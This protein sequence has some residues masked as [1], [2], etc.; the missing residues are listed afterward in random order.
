M[1]EPIIHNREKRW[2]MVFDAL[3]RAKKFHSRFRSSCC[4]RIQDR[5]L[6]ACGNL[7]NEE[8]SKRMVEMQINSNRSGYIL[9]AAAAL[10]VLVILPFSGTPMGRLFKTRT[11]V[12]S[13][14]WMY[15]ILALPGV[16]KPT[17]VQAQGNCL[18]PNHDL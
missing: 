18:V 4:F 14:A 11:L 15:E 10:T 7:P 5:G 16:Q 2:V 1:N 8:I 9:A 3:H 6:I 17:G 13:Y 12:N